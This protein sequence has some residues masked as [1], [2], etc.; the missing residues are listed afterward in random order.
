MSGV[1]LA[2]VGA[3][4]AVGQEMLRILE[5]RGFGHGELRLLASARSAGR[6]ARYGGRDLEIDELGE[7]SFEGI[8]IALFC[9]SGDV[10]RA[11][12][13]RAVEAGAHVIDNSSAYRMDPACP[14]VVPEVNADALDAV[15]GVPAII[16]NPN[17]STIIMLV[18]VD[19]L[20]RAFGVE[21]LVVS[22]YQA[23]SGAG[24][25][26]MVELREQARAVLA[27]EARPPEVFSEPCAFN[28]FSHDSAMDPA[29]GRN[30]EEQKMIDEARKIWSDP[31][32]RVTATC[33][34]VPV[35]RAHTES[36]NVR[37]GRAAGEAEVRESL[38][39]AP[40]VAI[41]DDRAANRFPTPLRA[42]DGDDVLVGRIRPDESQ[43]REG[44]GWRG[45]DLLVS[46]DQLRKGAALNA[47]QIAELLSV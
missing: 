43:E 46:S 15:R 29:T 1:N 42:S 17:C 26:A 8:D 31:S 37:L 6:S 18:A 2:I 13:P 38:A 11:W 44:E 36:I 47:V 12:A 4:G 24:A 14:L 33:V 30:V 27:G 23:V 20:R 32:L 28:V 34:R 39:S 5:Q 40:G 7:R 22:T 9:A 3:S 19:P 45:F 25:A 16:A 41:V 35:F 10:A 21:R